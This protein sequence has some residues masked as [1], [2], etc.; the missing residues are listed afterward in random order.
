MANILTVDNLTMRF[1]GIV[2]LN[3]V[4]FGVEEG[5]ITALIG[6]NGA[7]KTTVF[8]CVTGFYKA[9]EG[10]LSLNTGNAIIN[11]GE[12]LGPKLHF[13]DL[14]SGHFLKK[15]YYLAFGGNHLVVKQGLARTFQ[16][17]RLFK[18]MT[19]IENLLVAQHNQMNRNLLHGLF[20]TKSF[21]QSEQDAI[22]KA[23]FWL[24]ELN[25]EGESNTLAGNLPYGKAKRLE[26]ARSMCTN[27]KII[28][29]DEPAAGLNPRETSELSEIIL[30][31]KEN[32][33]VTV[34]L[35]EHDMSLV[36]KISEH[37]VVLDHGEIIA[38]GAPREIKNDPAV[39]EAYLGSEAV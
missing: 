39:I 29:L 28:C 19:V 23:L 6:P 22:E 37:V 7:G 36:M 1:G 11:V 5:S 16:N 27:P 12:L 8:N 30:K 31:L 21:T 13:K 4:S 3:N 10:T 33:K 38:N 14:L 24:K 26:I 25:L 20:S 9:T 17:I 32:H 2:A 15:L 35:I 34:L 18:D